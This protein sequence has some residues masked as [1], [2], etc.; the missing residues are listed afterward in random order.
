MNDVKNTGVKIQLDREIEMVFSLNVMSDAV[1]KYGKMDNL[2][3]DSGKDLE[4]T[5]WLVVQ[6]VNE[7]IEIYNDN[8]PDNKQ[9]L[10]DERKLCR[11][12]HGLGGFDV[13]QQK[14]QEAIL[15][16]LPADRVQ[17]VEELGKNLI[18]VQSQM[19]RKQRRK[20]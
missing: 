5:K 19:N 9:P 2:L 12:V 6:M 14:V 8:H 7:G 4:V 15:Q 11:Y 3:N 1:K 13:L 10:Y 17:Q 18:A 16:G 20:K